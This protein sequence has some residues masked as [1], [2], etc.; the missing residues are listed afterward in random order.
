MF[1][2]IKKKIIQLLKNKEYKPLIENFTSLSGLQI[3]GYV[4]PLIT[5][6]YLVRVLW[7]EKYGLIA[8]IFINQTL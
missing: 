6:P 4:L 3:A 8:F 7:P 1:H 2:Q 5:L